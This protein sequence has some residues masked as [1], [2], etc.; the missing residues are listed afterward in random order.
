MEWKK[1]I[2]LD[3]IDGKRRVRSILDG[4]EKEILLDMID[5]KRRGRSILDVMEKGNIA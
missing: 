3:M 2:L 5:G 1:E 4:M